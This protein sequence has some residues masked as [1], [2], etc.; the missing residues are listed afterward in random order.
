[1]AF[2]DQDSPQ[3]YQSWAPEDIRVLGEVSGTVVPGV[4][5]LLRFVLASEGH[6]SDESLDLMLVLHSAINGKG[7]DYSFVGAESVV[8]VASEFCLIDCSYERQ[9]LQSVEMQ[10]NAVLF[11]ALHGDYDTALEGAVLL[12]KDSHS[13]LSNQATLA[14]LCLF[15]HWEYLTASM[16]AAL[17]TRGLTCDSIGSLMKNVAGDGVYIHS[18][19]EFVDTVRKLCAVGIFSIAIDTEGQANVC[20]ERNPAGLFLLFTD[21]VE[22]AKSLAS[23]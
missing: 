22:M 7:N 9:T 20:I 6:V 19:L 4:L 11:A 16:L 21:R 17:L 15:G 23:L 12:S 14:S 8:A 2:F 18:D 10:D 5:N 13:L 1:M 3:Q